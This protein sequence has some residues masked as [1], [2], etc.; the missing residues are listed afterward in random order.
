MI[1]ELIARGADVNANAPRTTPLFMAALNGD[2]TVLEQLAE[3]GA[4]AV[5]DEQ[6]FAIAVRFGHRPFVEELLERGAEITGLVMARAVRSTRMDMIDL[7]IEHDGSLC[8]RCEDGSTMLFYIPCD[9]VR[10]PL[11]ERIIDA[12]VDVNAVNNTGETALIYQAACLPELVEFLLDRGADPTMKNA[13]GETA[14]DWAVSE[15]VRE[16]LHRA[17]EEPD[18]GDDEP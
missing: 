14:L 1:E 18:A 9:K 8:Q 17:M 7:L 2:V 11:W 13:A 5:N 10:R 16:L 15:E 12:G 6:A 3:A 4:D